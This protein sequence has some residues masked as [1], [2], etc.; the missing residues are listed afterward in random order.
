MIDQDI[1]N[2]KVNFNGA[3]GLVFINDKIIVFRRDNKTDKFPLYIDLPGGGKENNESPFETFKREVKE[4]FGIDIN[5]SDI[6]YSKKYKSIFDPK[7][8]AYFI[9]AKPLH[10]KENDIIF[11]DEGLYYFLITPK[12]FIKLGDA[13][14]RQQNKVIDYLDYINNIKS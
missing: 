9:V 12:D 5:I 7:I 13:V 1:F 14:E 3:K 2:N 8:P 4:E 6:E 11:G 10:L